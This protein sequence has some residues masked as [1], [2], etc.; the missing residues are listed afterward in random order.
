MSG[1]W[2]EHPERLRFL[3]AGHFGTGTSGGIAAARRERLAAFAHG[4]YLLEM[5]WAQ[6][7]HATL[8]RGRSSRRWLLDYEAAEAS[9]GAGN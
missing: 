1:F 8:C 5:H 6:V 9:Y 7:H 2:A 3:V 4:I